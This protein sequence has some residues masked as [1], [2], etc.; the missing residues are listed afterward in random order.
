MNYRGRFVTLLASLIACLTVFVTSAA[1]STAVTTTTVRFFQPYLAS[2]LN[3]A[4]KVTGSGSGYC[5]TGSNQVAD[6][7]AYR[8][9]EGNEIL[10]P[11]FASPFGSHVSVVAC[12]GP[13]TGLFL[14][15]LT[16]ALPTSSNDE[17]A[18]P[19]AGWL[20]QLANGSHCQ[21]AD[22]A[23]GSVDGVR[24][25]YLCGTSMAGRLNWSSEPW[26]VE[27]IQKGETKPTQQD[28]AVAWGA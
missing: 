18:F 11:C 26:H 1:G 4:L 21:L 20:L 16:K 22:G 17:D 6:P 28:V 15:R 27:Y 12:G 24:V 7:N 5:W 14:L 8:C 19:Q 23:T 25:A 3:H 2:G 10:D 9:F 13:W